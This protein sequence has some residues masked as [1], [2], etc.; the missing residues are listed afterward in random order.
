MIDSAAHRVPLCTYRLQLNA[1]F[2]FRDAAEIVD[3]LAELGVSD[4]YLSP[5]FQAATGSTHGYDACDFNRLNDALGGKAGFEA[6]ST[7]ARRHGMGIL[8]DMVPNHMGVT[9]PQNHWWWNMLKL[10]PDSPHAAYFDVDWN[11]PVPGLKNKVLLPVLGSDYGATLD[12]G[13]I[14]L[15]VEDSEIVVIYFDRRFPAC[16]GSLAL[17]IRQ[18]AESVG[19]AEPELIALRSRLEAGDSEALDPWK[20]WVLSDRSAANRIDAALARFNGDDDAC[21]ERLDQFLNRQWYRLAWWRIANEELNYRRFFDITGLGGLRVEVPRVFDAAHATL[22]DL[23]EE[24]HI[25]GLRIDHPD[26]L[27]DP[28][29]Y[30]QRLQTAAARRWNLPSENGPERTRPLYVLIEKIL[31]PPESLHNAWPVAGTT[32][33]DFLNR[34]NSLFVDPDRE[35]SIVGFYRDFTG[36]HE[37]F[38]SLVRRS[39]LEILDQSLVT[40]LDKATR[41]LREFAAGSRHGR[42]LT[43]RRIHAALRE[44]IAAFPVYRTYISDS[45]PHPT[46]A[47]LER[48]RHGLDAAKARCPDLPDAL[49]NLLAAM[50]ESAH[51]SPARSAAARHWVMKFQQLT[52]PV[53]AKGIEDTAFYRY[54]PLVSVNEVGGHPEQLGAA[55]ASFHR[56][57]ELQCRHWPHTMLASATHDTK[58]GED[59]RARIN[60]LGERIDEW[61]VAVREWADLNAGHRTDLENGPAPDRNDEYLIYQSLVGCWPADS[62]NLDPI[63]ERLQPYL[64][65]ACREAKRHTQWLNPNAAYESATGRFIERILDSTSGKEFLDRFRPFADGIAAL[66]RWN[67]AAQTLLKLT[68][69][70]VPDIYQ[71]TECRDL[72][73]VDPDNRRPVDYAARRDML[74]AVTA[75]SGNPDHSL[76]LART[77]AEGDS[78]NDAMK[79]FIVHR[80][81]QW[82][83]NRRALFQNG[84]YTA[85]EP[86][87]SRA[88]HA[89]AFARHLDDATAIII[90]PRLVATLLGDGGPGGC[91][92][93]SA[94]WAE[95]ALPIPEEWRDSTWRNVFTEQTLH[96]SDPLEIHQA[97]SDFPVALLERVGPIDR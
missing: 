84:G 31:C 28:I 78:G 56:E 27:W 23:I 82:R 9:D 45:A 97:L 46:R 5:I 94:I 40:E 95:T 19:A 77:L 43:A 12:R 11:S 92:V 22:L 26:G 32:G 63:R 54:L 73:L 51:F 38:T 59:V 14:R 61:S 96:A 50:F 83:K 13:E 39:K 30:C 17:I 42:D 20:Q 53:M 76:T 29:E 88:R 4:L 60:L 15:G 18:I 87:G 47:D 1:G 72:S 33:Y 36:N 68:C 35:Q 80:T 41:L 21:R 90:A 71:G 7:E 10:G 81:L 49:W 44:F 67:G 75:G 93:G 66:A 89:V 69:P 3:Y 6:L 70:G 48:I 25:T 62:E 52:G 65:K 91:P 85:L 58:R 57:N 37:A 34:M 74:R 79:I 8:V 64:E 55:P 2:T 16:P 86:I 24:G